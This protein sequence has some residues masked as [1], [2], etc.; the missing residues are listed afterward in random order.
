MTS[1]STIDFPSCILD[2]LGIEHAYPLFKLLS[3]CVV[4]STCACRVNWL[5]VY[6]LGSLPCDPLSLTHDVLEG[7][8][9]SFVDVL[10]WR[11]RGRRLLLRLSFDLLAVGCTLNRRGR[12]RGSRTTLELLLNVVSTE[13]N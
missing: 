13:I 4:A 8:G 5:A 12:G 9:G 6:I 7:V 3:E 11:R 10:H 1:L 2:C